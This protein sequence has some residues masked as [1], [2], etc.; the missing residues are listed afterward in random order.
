MSKEVTVEWLIAHPRESR[1]TLFVLL[2]L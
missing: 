1:V 2:N